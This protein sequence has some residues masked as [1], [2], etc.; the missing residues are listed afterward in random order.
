MK[1][2]IEKRDITPQKAIEILKKNGIEID[3]KE[4][5]IILEF[6]Y[7]FA[8]LS[9]DQYLKNEQKNSQKAE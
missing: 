2:G 8:K 5:L 3:E 6:L 1:L 9:V 4:A 7:F